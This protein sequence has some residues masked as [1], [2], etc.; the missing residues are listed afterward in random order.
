MKVKELISHL[1]KHYDLQQ[2]I[3]VAIWCDKDIQ[4]RREDLNIGQCEEVLDYIERKH[5][6]EIGISWYTI[7]YVAEE[8]FPKN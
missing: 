3:A 2:V 4:G 8:L 7:D 6:P 5:D 1:Q